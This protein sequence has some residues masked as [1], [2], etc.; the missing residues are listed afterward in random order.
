MQQPQRG[1]NEFHLDIYWTLLG[2]VVC[3]SVVRR[4]FRSMS[5]NKQAAAAAIAAE[6]ATATDKISDNTQNDSFLLPLFIPSTS[7]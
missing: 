1:D 4:T 7:S 6:I 3:M 5:L 2:L